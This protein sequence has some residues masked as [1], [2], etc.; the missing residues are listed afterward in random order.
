MDNSSRGKKEVITWIEW[1]KT[2]EIRGIYFQY[3]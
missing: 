3:G 2:K 1:E